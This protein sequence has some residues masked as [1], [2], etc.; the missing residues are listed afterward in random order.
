M[1][2]LVVTRSLSCVEMDVAAFLFLSLHDGCDW[3]RG[4]SLAL[5]PLLSHLRY[6][7]QV[8]PIR[9]QYLWPCANDDDSVIIIALCPG[10][11]R[12]SGLFKA[13]YRYKTL[14]ACTAA[15]TAFYFTYHADNLQIILGVLRSTIIS[16]VIRQ[17]INVQR[18]FQFSQG[19]RC[20]PSC[21]IKPRSYKSARTDNSVVSLLWCIS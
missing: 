15:T 6:A 10:N 16:F 20:T 9:S 12:L 8:V 14:Y 1:H 2:G 17:A 5:K 13:Q 11:Y 19:A 21:I 18:S 7:S 3:S 4:S